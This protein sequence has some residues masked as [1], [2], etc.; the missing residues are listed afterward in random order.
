[1]RVCL[2]NPPRIQPKA[3]GKPNVFPPI[4]LAYVAAVLEKEHEVRI[5]D[6]PTEGWRNL[7]EVGGNTYRVGLSDEEIADRIKRWSPSVVVIEIPFSGWSKTAFEVASTIKS[8]NKEIVI[9]LNGQH[10]S[11]RPEAC[12]SKPS[13]DFVVIG[14]PEN[15]ISELISAIE[16]GKQDFKKIRGIAFIQNGKT[17]ITPPRPVI[18]DLDSLPFPARHLLPMEEYHVAVKENPLRGEIRKP[19]TIV[20]TSRGCPYNCIFCSSCTVWGRKWRGRSPENVVDELEHI[21]KTYNVKQVDFADD[22]MTSDKK[23]MEAIC[24]LIVKRRLRFEWFTPNGIRADTL[25]ENLLTKMKKAGC[26]KIRIAPESGVQ[27][28]VDEIIK[29]NLDLKSVEQ[30]VVLCKKVG[31]K[32]GCF[33]VIGLIGETKEDIEE[34]IRFAY[35]LRQ[36]GADTFIFSIAMPIY[37]TEL[38]EQAKRGG[39]LIDGFCEDALASVDPLIETPEFTADDLRELCAR[40]NLVNPTFTRGKVLRA[41]RNPRKTIKMLLGK[42]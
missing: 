1:M 34:T 2:I 26:K 25:D 5:I 29:K 23:R 39:F 21:V 16:K 20:I 28:V 14:E 37:G 8:V 38:Y 32:V 13:V 17:V 3:W 40:A 24:D 10:P 30:A 22:N 11:A 12:L 6:A 19:W 33:F 42:K 31:I 36:L 35:K 7:K 18:E 4:S 15:T 9:V 41:I 27:R